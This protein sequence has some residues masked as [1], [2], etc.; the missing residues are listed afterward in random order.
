MY[1]RQSKYGLF[2]LRPLF[3]VAVDHFP[4]DQPSSS[5][6]NDELVISEY[7]EEVIKI[8]RIINPNKYFILI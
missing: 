6:V 1:K 2:S 3:E 8:N 4:E 5:K 7:D